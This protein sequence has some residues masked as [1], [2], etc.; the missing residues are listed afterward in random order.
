MPDTDLRQTPETD[1]AQR[2]KQQME[3]QE[4]PPSAAVREP[5]A[6][7]DEL[8]SL[9]RAQLARLQSQGSAAPKAEPEPAPE[10]EPDPAPEP[11]PA[12][13]SEPAPEQVAEPES[14]SEPEPV[15]VPE[16]EPEPEPTPDPV[17]PPAP[18]APLASDDELNGVSVAE[19][20]DSGAFLRG[21]DPDI[22]RR[23]RAVWDSRTEPA[24]ES[25]AAEQSAAKP[26]A[27]GTPAAS[28]SATDAPVTEKPAAAAPAPEA[29]PVRR[30]AS[31]VPPTSRPPQDPLQIGLDTARSQPDEPEKP[32]EPDTA[33]SAARQDA[34]RP[35]V[36]GQRYTVRQS[37]PPRRPQAPARTPD[38]RT[39]SDTELYIDLG[40][41]NELRRTPD[42]SARADAALRD[43]M[44]RERVGT[45]NAV[46]AAYRGQEYTGAAMTDG[47][48]RR[49]RFSWRMAL[50]R[51]TC[52][53]VGFLCGLVYDTLPRWNLPGTAA[54]TAGYAYPLLGVALLLLFALPSLHRLGLGLR[55]LWDFEPVRY[56]VPGMAL[57]A[58]ILHALL[59]TAAVGD[60]AEPVP[61]YC[62]AALLLLTV[63]CLCDL[64]S[65]LAERRSFRIVSSGRARTVITLL[66]A[67]GMRRT[68]RTD[69]IGFAD[70]FADG[71]ADGYAGSYTAGS[72]GGA[73]AR[74][75]APLTLR[76]C[77]TAGV[78]NFFALANR[79]S[80][81]L[82]H[83]NYLMP[84]AVLMAIAAAGVSILLGGSLLHDALPRF[85]AAYL[86]C[87]PGAFLLS[88]IL[89]FA[90]GNRALSREGCALLGEAVPEQY[91]PAGLAGR[92][93][94]KRPAHTH[95][96]LPDGFALSP[97]LPNEIT[98]RDDKR[99]DEWLN[100]AH[101]LFAL[102]DCPLAGF[103][104]PPAREELDALR[105]EPAEGG[106]D[107]LRLYM[108]DTRSGGAVEVMLG[109]YEALAPRGVRLPPRE[110]ESSYKKTQ[111]AQVLYIAFDRR[112]RLACT[113]GL[114]IRPLFREM[115]VRLRAL[116]CRVSVL[117]YD[118]LARSF[119][120]SGEDGD[121]LH[122]GLF[123][124]RRYGRLYAPR[125]GGIVSVRDGLDVLR[126][127]FA[128]CRIR[129]ANRLGVLL[130][131]LWL[132]T[133]GGLT[134]ASPALGIPA[135]VLPLLCCGWYAVTSGLS[136]LPTLLCVRQTESDRKDT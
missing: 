22:S 132:L 108:T 39:K 43:R 17:P 16:S 62:G 75:D 123:R 88:V 36:R 80:G 11:E 73:G 54:F 115:T 121:D 135:D 71:S 40:Y 3:R 100:L 112:F 30:Q 53:G 48:L 58:A 74:R 92:R 67:P 98:V 21:L 12:L 116:G 41:E 28:P 38:S 25:P 119:P 118:P 103:G 14:E 91:A 63:T 133:A 66:A 20:L 130:G 26:V 68:D 10:P 77:R 8:D 86:A 61:L 4:E 57:C 42:G 82:S 34:A 60:G 55:S 89:P 93:A 106:T 35:G 64:L 6:A 101:R 15:P 107:F 105:L 27:A 97:V 90:V 5:D 24:A 99:A 129:T 104:D 52:A 124:P 95:L 81:S 1:W 7:Q 128:C 69:D 85:T 50:L 47:V 76:L 136:C 46:P 113:C 111:D 9:L 78:P 29:P 131:W 49:Y 83:L 84:A 102:L 23:I 127:Y 51:L 70:G 65:L 13:E 126:G 122:V 72:A 2:L 117:S 125:S 114:R 110:A 96:I 56:A 59:S 45:Q 33:A 94:A 87:L 31:S 120:L 79:Y 109:S 19:L 134:V 18:V 44:K 37:A 32:D